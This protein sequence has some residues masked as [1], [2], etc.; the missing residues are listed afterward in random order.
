MDNCA[1]YH[2][3][4]IFEYLQSVGVRAIFLPPYSPDLNPIEELF[5]YIKYYLKE[6]DEVIQALNGDLVEVVRS[7]FNSITPNHCKAWIRHAIP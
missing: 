2:I 7:A 1:I 5:S 6:H 4:D 3:Q